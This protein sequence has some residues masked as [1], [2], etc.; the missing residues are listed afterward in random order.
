[1]SWTALKLVNVRQ[2]ARTLV[3][4]VRMVRVVVLAALAVACPART[5]PCPM[6]ANA[7]SGVLGVCVCGAGSLLD[8]MESAGAALPC[9]C[10]VVRASVEICGDEAGAADVKMLLREGAAQS[11]FLC[12]YSAARRR[13]LKSTG[14]S[15]SL[16]LARGWYVPVA[17]GCLSC[18]TYEGAE[19]WA[20]DC[21]CCI[22]AS[23]ESP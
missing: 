14:E 5:K 10:V 18:L 9:V 6:V 11:A 16:L 15:V 23:F 7:V 4:A 3:A 17:R 8:D 2:A 12:V 13:A 21:T 19:S 20:A 1:M 22:V